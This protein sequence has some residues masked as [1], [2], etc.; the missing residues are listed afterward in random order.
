[1]VNSPFQAN[2]TYLE[3]LQLYDTQLLMAVQ[4]KGK[5]KP[6]FGTDV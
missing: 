2:N 4:D 1:M 5:P 6:E 3:L